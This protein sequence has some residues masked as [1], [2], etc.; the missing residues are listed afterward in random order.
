[1]NI[2]SSLIRYSIWAFAC[3]PCLTLSAQDKGSQRVVTVEKEYNPDVE[4]A[5]KVDVLP[6]NQLP[7]VSRNPIEYGT[8]IQ[9]YRGSRYQ[10]GPGIINQMQGTPTNGYV[11]GGA[12]NYGQVD[13]K[14]GYLFRLSEEDELNT[15]VS[16]GGT[17]STL[18]NRSVP[19]YGNEDHNWA[20][21]YF[22]TEANADYS[23]YFENYTL[24][25]QA[26][27]CID[28]YNYYRFL[29]RPG[30]NWYEYLEYG[31]TSNQG[32][33]KFSLGANFRSNEFN[34]QPLHFTVSTA[35]SHFRRS[36][37]ADWVGSA[38]SENLFHTVAD[39]YGKINDDDKQQIGMKAELDNLFYSRRYSA[40]TSLE[41][42]P[43]YNLYYYDIKMHLGA[44]VNYSA[45]RG[46]VVQFAPDITMEYSFYD[47]Y[48]VYGE[49]GGGRI[50]NDFRRLELGNPYWMS[51][52]FKNSHEH[53]NALIGIKGNADRTFSF[54]F[55]GGY[56]I[57]G[58]DVCYM[59]LFSEISD[60]AY[61]YAIN[62]DTKHFF[63]S[64][65][66]DFH[67]PQVANLKV[68]AKMYAWD[69]NK[70]AYL[71]MKPKNEI[72]ASVEFQILSNLRFNIA[73]NFVE[74]NRVNIEYYNLEP[75]NVVG[76]DLN[77]LTPGELSSRASGTQS[78]SVKMSPINNLS[79]GITLDVWDNFSI[80]AQLNNILN[81]KYEY[82][83][84]YPA[85]GISCFGGLS[86]RF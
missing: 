18:N 14:A 84:S 83:Y 78:A 36:H 31:K 4:S 59:N 67:F 63:A 75:I 34:S 43:Y 3:L 56:N 39:L 35:Y 65:E 7:T 29:S 68:G 10:L 17:S 55:N 27:L 72:N 16:F 2:P 58:D 48:S 13:L 42:N 5:A 62:Q 77:S 11:Q 79:A 1:M 76:L 22:R 71:V 37:M 33:R 82:Y 64:G 73:Y 38:L 30:F 70:S 19:E 40:S 51:G 46:N 69:D 50:L 53:L 20:N 45:G 44:K 23:H 81:R 47:G 32:H 52:Q 80:Y 57:T 21:H 25:V 12:G 74:R 54:N 28:D 41:L 8:G 6:E 61:L 60:I 49:L 66:L 24:G 9:A 26:N 15:T 85:Q 86:Y